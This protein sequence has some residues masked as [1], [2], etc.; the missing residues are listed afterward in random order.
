LIGFDLETTGIN[1]ETD[2]PIEVGALLYS[3]GQ[4]KCLESTGYLVK[5]DVP[6]S[7]E[8]TEIT[9]ITQAAI[10]KF[11]YDSAEALDAFLNLAEQADAFVGQNVIRFDKRF[12][13]NWAKRHNRII[14]NKLW[15]DT[16]TDI[17]GITGKHLG[18][19][20][21]DHGFLNLF[22]HQALADVQTVIKIIGMHDINKIVERAQS[23]TIVLIAH[24]KREDNELAKK[25]K[26]RW[27]PPNVYGIWWK[28]IKEID[29]EEEIKA[30]PFNVSVAPPEVL[31][32]KLWYDN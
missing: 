12:L 9:G 20:A 26:F 25:R 10:D 24:Q 5:S 13:E 11:G 27:S 6:I 17:P 2:R 29:K 14:P 28:A 32:E 31:L 19:Q 8:I 30:A 22:P 16:M 3:T 1:P 18:Y 4:K 21:A 15:I 7:P 23:P